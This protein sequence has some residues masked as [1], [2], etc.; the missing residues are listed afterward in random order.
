MS[1]VVAALSMSLDGYVTGP[2]PNVEHGLGSG[3]ETIQQWAFSSHSSP[4]DR[5]VLETSSAATGAVIMGRHTFEFIDGPHG[6]DDQVS[7]AYDHKS[8]FQLPV[9]VVTHQKPEQTR[10][11]AGFTFITGGVEAAVSAARGAAGERETV[12]MGGAEVIDQALI[13]GLVDHLRIHLSP[14][15][16]GSG[17][18]L[19]DLVDERLLLTQADVVVTPHATHLTYRMSP[20]GRNQL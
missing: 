5:D 3:G 7:Y 2:E 18:R 16:M 20:D 10:L 1:P 13:F 12:I 19:F 11:T 8:P 6:W 4:Q 15:I 17:T 9:F 14:V